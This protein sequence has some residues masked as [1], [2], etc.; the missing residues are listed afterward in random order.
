[1]LVNI[2]KLPSRM[3]LVI[4]QLQVNHILIPTRNQGN[5]RLSHVSVFRKEIECLK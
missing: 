2:Q 4:V 1:M 5:Y 3:Q